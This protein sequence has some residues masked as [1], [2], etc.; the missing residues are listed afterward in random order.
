MCCCPSFADYLLVTAVLLSERLSLKV[1]ISER[2]PV[3]VSPACALASSLARAYRSRFPWLPYTR[4][5]CISKLRAF[6]A[7]G[8]RYRSTAISIPKNSGLMFEME[9]WREVR[10]E[11]NGASW[12]RAELSEL[13]SYPFAARGKH[14]GRSA[15]F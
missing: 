4:T 11:L 1:Q 2:L 5:T 12:Y 8:G 14:T 6:S 7:P 3:E 15:R 10:K 13:Y 9:K